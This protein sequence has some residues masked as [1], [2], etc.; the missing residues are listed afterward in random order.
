MGTMING[1]FGVVQRCIRATGGVRASLVISIS[2]CSFLVWIINFH[3]SM[4][5]QKLASWKKDERVYMGGEGRQ[6][7]ERSA[8][9][10]YSL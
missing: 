3:Y 1:G 5:F 2:K 7:K 6:G 8:F 9:N 4:D 10:G